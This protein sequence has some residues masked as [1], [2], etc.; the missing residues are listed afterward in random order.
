MRELILEFDTCWAQEALELI[1]PDWG[2][3]PHPGA[4]DTTKVSGEEDVSMNSD[5]SRTNQLPCHILPQY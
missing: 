3:G 2:R 4:F 1:A 5:G